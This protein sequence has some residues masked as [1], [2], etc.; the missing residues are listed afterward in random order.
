M[1]T[2]IAAVTLA[3]TAAL[4]STAYAAPT[5]HSTSSYA[6][7]HTADASY[8]ALRT[9]PAAPQTLTAPDA[10]ETCA[11]SS[12]PSQAG[13][14][15]DLIHSGGPFPYE[16]DGTVFQN[17]EGILPD[18]SSGYY[19]EYTVITP[20]SP[21]RG[22]RRLVGGGAETDPEHVYYTSDHYASFCEVDENS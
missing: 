9:A 6:A 5:S 18:E 2:L 17:R 15:L 1:R 12:L 21:D 3:T 14:T 16:Q 22:A 13:D 7:P 20:G 19:H 11:L 8:V 10:I 4:G